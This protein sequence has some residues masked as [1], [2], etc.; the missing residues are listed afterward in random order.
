M[1]CHAQPVPVW[2]AGV[3]HPGASE[4]SRDVQVLGAALVVVH[5]LAHVQAVLIRPETSQPLL[6]LAGGLILQALALNE[7]WK[8]LVWTNQNIIVED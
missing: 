8:S 2:V 4:G 5:H 7:L 1:P 3:P 6:L